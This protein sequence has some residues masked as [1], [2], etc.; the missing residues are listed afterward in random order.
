M[1]TTRT[2]YQRPDGT[3]SWR[4]SADDNEII[5]SGSARGYEDE[6]TARAIADKVIGGHFSDAAKRRRPIPAEST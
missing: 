1:S 5:A 2:V 4:L 6:T 3:W